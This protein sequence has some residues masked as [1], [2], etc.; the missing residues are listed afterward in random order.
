MKNYLGYISFRI[1]ISFFDLIP[2]W[3]LYR[4]SDLVYIL[5]YY[6][7][8][9]RKDTV[10]SN[11]KR[12]FPE[13]TEKERLITEK[14][15]YRHLADIFIEG[16]KAINLSDKETIKRY[17]VL[18]PEAPNI[19]YTEGKASLFV[20]SHVNNWEYGALGCGLQVDPTVLVFY[21]PLKNQ[22]INNYIRNSRQKKGT[23]MAPV[24]ETSVYFEKYFPERPMYIMLSDQ[25]PSNI[26]D[27]HWVDFFGTETA[28]LHGPAKYAHKYKLPIY[29][30]RTV[31]VKR[32]FYEV[33]AELIIENPM[34]YSQ[35]EISGIFTKKIEE[36][37][38]EAPE[39]W[40]WSHKR[41]K[42]SREELKK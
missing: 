28:V 37:I 21:K 2:F 6:V 19:P 32:G 1:F 17:K 42:R 26:K 24:G 22:L 5:L 33:S 3:L 38:K 20:G 40:L 4:I 27:C 16:I 10:K 25:S 15:F 7:V 18:T 41:W 23:V 29:F 11:L 9:Y 14:K 13:W 12:A 35:D 30:I 36:L 31:K 39:F 34:E 8:S